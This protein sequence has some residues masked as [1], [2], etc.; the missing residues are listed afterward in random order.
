[1]YEPKTYRHWVRGHDLISFNVVVKETD[2]YIRASTNLK[3]KALKLVLK[4]RDAL[5][6]YIERH[7]DAFFSH[8]LCPECVELL[9]SHEDWYKKRNK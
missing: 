8:G 3:R 5:E 7:S 9:Y 1:M 4:Y 2:L 6:K